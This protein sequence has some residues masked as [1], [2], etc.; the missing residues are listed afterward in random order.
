MNFSDQFQ[1][2]FSLGFGLAQGSIPIIKL[3]PSLDCMNLVRKK[4]ISC[5]LF[6]IP[7][8]SLPSSTSNQNVTFS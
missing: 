1:W 5:F 2:K 7:N 8:N 4:V 3:K 6:S